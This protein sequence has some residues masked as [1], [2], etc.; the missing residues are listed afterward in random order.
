MN[1]NPILVSI[2]VPIFNS[3]TNLTECINSLINQSLIDIEIILINDGSIDNSRKII[4][5]FSEIDNRI[6]IINKKNEGVSA[7]RNLGIKLARGKFVGFIDSDDYINCKMYE[8]LYY[9]AIKQNAKLS[10]CK[11]SIINEKC[12][13]DEKWNF[14]YEDVKSA[15]FILKNMIGP[16]NESDF[17]KL[18]SLMGSTC[19]CI[20]NKDVLVKNSI[21]FNEE[22]TYAED[23][24]FNIRYL[25]K[26]NKVVLI[27]EILYYYRDNENSLSRGYRNDLFIM[28]KKLTNEIER[29]L[30]DNNMILMDKRLNFAYFKY[31]IELMKNETKL[32]HSI[33]N[34]RYTNIKKIVKDGDFDKKIKAIN[35][36]KLGL[37]NKFMYLMFKYKL[38]SFGVVF[39]GIRKIKVFLGRR[40]FD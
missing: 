11:F 15:E 24:L 2:I 19:R 5:K 9:K 32:V 31:G 40:R 21:F 20:Y 25:T 8:K 16:D 3:E 35:I 29:Y 22:I 34:N 28:I 18:V 1:V 39:L 30:R 38:T 27:N 23:L 13:H 6:K 10:M 7:T 12:N 36:R 26:I 4:E 37:K 33:N 14:N 17:N